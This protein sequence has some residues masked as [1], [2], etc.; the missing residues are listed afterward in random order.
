MARTVTL[1]QL[2][3]RARERADLV[4][5]GFITTGAGAEDDTYVQ[6]SAA[7]L[8]AILV[9]ADPDRYTTSVALTSTDT[10]FIAW[11]LPANFYK[12]RGVT[13]RVGGWTY[14]LHKATFDQFVADSNITVTRTWPPRYIMLGN[15]VRFAPALTAT[16]APTLWYITAQQPLAAGGLTFDGADGWDEW[17]VLDVAIKMLLKEESDTRPL[18]AAKAQVEA[19][20]IGQS[21]DRDAGEPYKMTDTDQQLDWYNFRLPPP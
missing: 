17:I 4:N 16:P 11:D 12:A 1:A 18:E 21:A 15:Q 9:D 10:A 7:A 5:S 3:T 19:R 20:I 14:T 6:E 8:H 2:V 13:Y